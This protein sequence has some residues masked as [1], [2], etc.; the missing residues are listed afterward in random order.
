MNSDR[1]TF[2][3]QAVVGAAGVG[4]AARTASASTAELPAFDAARPDAYWEAVRALYPLAPDLKYFNTGGLGPAASPVLARAEEVNRRLQSRV[5]HGHE[6]LGGA[7]ATLARF[8]GAD[9]AEISFLRN[10]TEGNS[11][12]AGGLKLSAGDEVIFESHAHPGGWY[13]WAQQHR[14]RGVVVRTF[15]PDHRDPAGNLARIRA[16]C[17]A[18]T[19]VVQVSHVTAPTGIVMPVDDIARF[20]RERGIWCHLDG[21]QSA[22]M[23]PFSLHA[24]GCDSFATSGHKWMGGPL[25]T[26][27]LYVRRDR[28]DDVAPVHVGSYSGELDEGTGELRI[29]GDAMRYEY[30]TRTPAAPLGLA[31]AVELQE[32]IG[33]ERIAAHGRALASRLA[34]QLALL[35]GVEILS[36]VAGPLAGAMVTFRSGVMPYDVLFKRLFY[37]HG[38]RCRPVS[39][40]KLNAV[41][42]SAHVFNTPAECDALVATAAEILRH[43]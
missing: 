16:L 20:C 28:L 41:R 14:L 19:R 3:R 15:E 30:G 25:E 12:I 35:P 8:L 26:G 39:E 6:L 33:R 42:V 11:V 34:E 38:F 4:L 29:S 17:T 7:R 37:G 9:A 24:I 21:A 31:A 27:V 40:E 22:G 2:L 1:R 32:R 43:A 18:R 13:P 23:I 36:P 10:A 5:E